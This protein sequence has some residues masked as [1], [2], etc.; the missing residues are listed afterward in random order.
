MM[1]FVIIVATVA[2]ATAVGRTEE[3]T[4]RAVEKHS[5]ETRAHGKEFAEL[6]MDCCRRGDG[7]ASEPGRAQP[8]NHYHHSTAGSVDERSYRAPRH[9]PGKN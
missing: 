1:T 9:W 4:N 5:V 6:S 2:T 3:P 8:G 7:Q